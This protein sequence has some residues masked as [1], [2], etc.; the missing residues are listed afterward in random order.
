MCAK[1]HSNVCHEK[2]RER[3]R[4]RKKEC[5]HV[6]DAEILVPTA[7]AMITKERER[8]FLW[9]CVRESERA[10]QRY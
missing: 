2:E 7:M 10:R 8:M 1:T 6:V 5:Q 9:V 3:E 4:E